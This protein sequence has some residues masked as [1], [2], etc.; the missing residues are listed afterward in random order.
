MYTHHYICTLFSQTTARTYT[1][2]FT[3]VQGHTAVGGECQH[4]S[5]D[6]SEALMEEQVH[7]CSGASA[8]ASQCL[9]SLPTKPKLHNTHTWPLPEKHRH[10]L[11][12]CL[13]FSFKSHS[14]CHSSGTNIWEPLRETSAAPH[15]LQRILTFGIFACRS[16]FPLTFVEIMLIHFAA[17]INS[18]P[19]RAWDLWQVNESTGTCSN[20]QK[21][22][23]K[24]IRTASGFTWVYIHIVWE[25]FVG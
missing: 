5:K 25:R 3:D 13:L 8:A 6:C 7:M 22:K 19:S 24:C 9:F 12:S 14:S 11:T 20:L 17:L 23:I 15:V 10:T 4:W 16:S 21:W 18:R 2:S 1:R